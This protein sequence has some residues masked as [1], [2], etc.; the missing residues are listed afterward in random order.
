ML[1]DNYTHN[2]VHLDVKGMPLVVLP[3]HRDI[4]EKSLPLKLVE[5]LVLNQIKGIRVISEYP[6]IVLKEL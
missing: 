4:S 5:D 3:G 1:I 6:S 2:S